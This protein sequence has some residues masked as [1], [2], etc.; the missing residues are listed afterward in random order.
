MWW[1]EYKHLGVMHRFR[2]GHE[3]E[4]PPTLAIEKAQKI[5]P[6]WKVP[7]TFIEKYMSGP[8]QEDLLGQE[9]FIEAKEVEVIPDGEPDSPDEISLDPDLMRKKNMYILAGIRDSTQ[10]DKDK[11]AAIKEL[12]KMQSEAPKPPGETLTDEQL[13]IEIA[14]KFG[15]LMGIPIPDYILKNERANIKS[16]E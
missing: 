16:I 4:I 10:Y 1:F 15:T 6:D 7:E 12:N 3:S 13:A 8:V 5:K 14:K 11:I 9:I 2:I